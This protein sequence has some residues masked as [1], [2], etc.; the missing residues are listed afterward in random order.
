MT[1]VEKFV[2]QRLFPLIECYRGTQADLKCCFKRDSLSDKEWQLY[3]KLNQTLKRL[4]ESFERLQFN[5]AIAALMELTRVYWSVQGDIGDELNDY[6]V[7]K[8]AQ[9]MAPLAPHLAEELWSSWGFE[10]SIFKSDWPEY[11][12]EAVT[13]DTVE[14]AVQVNGKLRATVEVEADADKDTVI[15]AAMDHERVKVYTEGKDIVKQIYVP[16]RLVNIVVK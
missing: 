10:G 7:I 4:T 2:A 11:D 16:G 14:I 9:A 15:A 8:A 5:T 12:P 6:C 13:G 1:G 3:I